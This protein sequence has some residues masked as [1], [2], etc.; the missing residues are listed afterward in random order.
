MS[1]QVDQ[2]QAEPLGE[3][4]NERNPVTGVVGVAVDENDRLP[5]GIAHQDVGQ[6]LAVRKSDGLLHRVEGVEV[7]L[8][9]CCG[10]GGAMGGG[11]KNNSREDPLR[12][13]ERQLLQAHSRVGSM[14]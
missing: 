4:G 14:H 3:I 2:D 6:R 7:D 9:R 1:A 10:G 5:L 13:G 11:A 8:L 12:G